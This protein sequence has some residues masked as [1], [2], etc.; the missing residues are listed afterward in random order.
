MASMAWPRRSKMS[1]IALASIESTQ[2]GKRFPRIAEAPDRGRAGIACRV[3]SRYSRFTTAHFAPAMP[4]VAVIDFETT[5]MSP[6]TG[7]RA[8]EIGAV[9]LRKGVVVDRYP[10]DD[11]VDAARNFTDKTGRRVSIEWTLIRDVNDTDEQARRLAPIAK[12]LGAHV[13]LIPMNPTPLT[14]DEP[15]TDER[16]TAFRDLLQSLGVNATV[17]VIRGR[18][19]DAACG[20]LRATTQGRRR[21]TNRR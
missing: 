6:E 20:Q 10:L 5:G 7:G 3:S 19:I 2:V 11:L 1:F 21:L 18:S 16:V 15:S 12:R 8:T 9:L 14:E 17:R 4:T 13:N